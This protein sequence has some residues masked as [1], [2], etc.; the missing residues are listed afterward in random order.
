MVHEARL[1]FTQCAQRLCE[2]CGRK[3]RAV[4]LFDLTLRGSE[5]LGL[6]CESGRD[7]TDP[8]RRC[9]SRISNTSGSRRTPGTLRISYDS[10]S[11]AWVRFGTPLGTHL[12]T[13]L[14][15]V[16]LWVHIWVST[17]QDKLQFYQRKATKTDVLSL[18]SRA[19]LMSALANVFFRGGGLF[20][21][22]TCFVS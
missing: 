21:R 16:Q 9:L 22:I 5:P 11:A 18:R 14:T 6:P 13:H 12:G 7:R 20:L 2:A 3:A 1:F 8:K 19:L 10:T 4:C 15:W 17:D